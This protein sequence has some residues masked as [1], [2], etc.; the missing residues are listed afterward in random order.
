MLCCEKFPGITTFSTPFRA[1]Y[2]ADTKV[3]DLKPLM[4]M[5]LKFLNCAH[6]RTSDLTPLRG[7]PLGELS[8]DFQAK[9]DAEILRSIK[10]LKK[11]NDQPAADFWKAVGVCAGSAVSLKLP[12][13]PRWRRDFNSTL[14]PSNASASN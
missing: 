4:D 5:K 11:I 14:P 1:I 12:S 9:R 10:T 7:M 13:A 8:C 3:A 2:P 6:T